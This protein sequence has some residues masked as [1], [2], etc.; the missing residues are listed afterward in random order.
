VFGLFGSLGFEVILRASTLITN[1]SD[2][3]ISKAGI[4]DKVPSINFLGLDWSEL[5]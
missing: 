5:T 2:I 3:G 4:V 1:I